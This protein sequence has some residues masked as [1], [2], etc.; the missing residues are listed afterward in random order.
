MLLFTYFILFVSVAPL[1]GHVAD[2]LAN[3]VSTVIIPE[4]LPQTTL[5]EIE[6]NQTDKQECQ[7]VLMKLALESIRDVW[8]ML[9]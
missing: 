6:V 8:N 2:G 3:V 7:M 4:F 9:L 5:Q 1:T